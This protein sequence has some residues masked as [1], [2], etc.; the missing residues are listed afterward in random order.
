M[1]RTLAGLASVATALLFTAT[2]IADD[3][4]V[5]GKIESL[6]AAERTLV[7]AGQTYRADDRTDYDDDLERFEDL[8]VGDRVEIDYIVVDGQRIA[9]EIEKDD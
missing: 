9:R 1:T 3:L 8:R 6:N 2:A 5:E 7:V 4:D